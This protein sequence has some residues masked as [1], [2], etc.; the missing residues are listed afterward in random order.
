M[1]ESPGPPTIVLLQ[2]NSVCISDDYNGNSEIRYYTLYIQ[3]Y[4]EGI[5]IVNT[6][7]ELTCYVQDSSASRVLD[8]KCKLQVIKA[9]STNE[10]G[11]SEQSK[12]LALNRS[13]AGVYICAGFLQ[14]Y[15]LLYNLSSL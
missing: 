5:Y 13:R 4:F 12:A 9:T 6:S 7:S 14:L 1:S 10:V 3:D 2:N 8:H 15:K 11:T